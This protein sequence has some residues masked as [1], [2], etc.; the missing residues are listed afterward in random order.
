MHAT[1]EVGQ[2]VELH[3]ASWAVFTAII[4][5]FYWT[6]RRSYGRLLEGAV[7]FEDHAGRQREAIEVN[8]GIVQFLV[9]DGA[10]PRP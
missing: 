3:D 2:S 5:V 10:A 9:E 7:L 4:G 6:L 1:A 8:D